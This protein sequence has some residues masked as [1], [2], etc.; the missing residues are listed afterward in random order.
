MEST[1]SSNELMRTGSGAIPAETDT[2][3]AS[4]AHWDA[5]AGDGC[6]NTTSTAM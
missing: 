4:N 6:T 2:R 3:D 5:N 1:L